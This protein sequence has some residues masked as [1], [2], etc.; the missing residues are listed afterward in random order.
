ADDV[1]RLG[2]QFKR[3]AS[4]D[5]ARKAPSFLRRFTAADK[6]AGPPQKFLGKTISPET[7][8]RVRTGTDTVAAVADDLDKLTSVV[9]DG[10]EIVKDIR[11]FQDPKEK[12]ADPD[13]AP[14]AWGDLAGK[15]PETFLG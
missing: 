4:Y 10:K 7:A 13:E 9:S 1:N 14:K 11:Q 3:S 2:G 15:V 6:P 5:D 8:F 12:Y